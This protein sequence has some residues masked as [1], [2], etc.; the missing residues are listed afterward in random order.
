[1]LCGPGATTV[2]LVPPLVE[3]TAPV[4]LFCAPAAIPVTFME[5]L[6]DA[7]AFRLA[8]DKLTLFVPSTAVIVPPPH[9]PVKPLGVASTKPAGKVSLKAIPFRV[10]ALLG[11][12]MVKLSEVVPFRAIEVA[13]NDL[14]MVGGTVCRGPETAI[15]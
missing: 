1:M 15:P 6:H 2:T 14:L 9:V 11:L 8:P 10:V 13:P 7:L 5:K 4:V 3:L 12:L